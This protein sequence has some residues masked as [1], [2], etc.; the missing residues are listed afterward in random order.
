MGADPGEREKYEDDESKKIRE[1]YNAVRRAAAQHTERQTSAERGS[2]SVVVAETFVEEVEMIEMPTP[3]APRAP[4]APSRTAPSR[5][6]RPASDRP[7][8]GLRRL[9]QP[10][11]SG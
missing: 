8:L 11:R 5:S 4:A 3:G 10:G 2:F 9:A 6:R 7:G 1:D